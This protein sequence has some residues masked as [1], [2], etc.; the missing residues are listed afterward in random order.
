MLSLCGCERVVLTDAKPLQP[1]RA[2]HITRARLRRLDSQTVVQREFMLQ[3]RRDALLK[4]W[5]SRSG[6]IATQH[7]L[8]ERIS[9]IDYE[10]G[11]L[12]NIIKN[13]SL[14]HKQN[15]YQEVIQ[16]IKLIHKP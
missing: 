7:R 5:L 14:E 9:L 12:N 11:I 16:T 10:L 4:K 6:D 15:C 8:N 13:R 2:R 1:K 3:K